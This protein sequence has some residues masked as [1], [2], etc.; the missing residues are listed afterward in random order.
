[1]IELANGGEAGRKRDGGDGKSS[2]LDQVAREV[3]PVRDPDFYRRHAQVFEKQAAQLTRPQADAAGEIF[4][5]A[6]IQHAFRNQAERAGN[7]RRSASPG[8]RARSGFRTASAA[9]PESGGF[10]RGRAREPRQVIGL[11]EGNRANGTAIHAR[12]GRADEEPAVKTLIP[13]VQRLPPGRGLK[14]TRTAGA[15]RLEGR[16]GA[17]WLC[18]SP[19]EVS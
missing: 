8:R 6:F 18:A 2:L 5:T 7:D 11:G 1:M 14:L 13:A 4:D 19:I 9:G 17:G 15:P 16:R 12:G 10:G 3:N